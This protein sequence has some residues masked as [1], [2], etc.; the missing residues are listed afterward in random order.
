MR[1]RGEIILWPAYFDSSRSRTEGRRIPLKI[2]VPSPSLR[3]ISEALKNL[4][5]DHRIVPDAAYPRLPWRKSGMIYVKLKPSLSK[6]KIITLV[7]KE[8]GRTK[9]MKKTF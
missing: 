2:A 4:G 8:M 7:A 1:R 6:Q 3:R 9:Q 5:L